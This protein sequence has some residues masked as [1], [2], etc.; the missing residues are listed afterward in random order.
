MLLP[1]LRGTHDAMANHTYV[2]WHP[3]TRVANGDRTGYT[4]IRCRRQSEGSKPT[5]LWAFFVELAGDHR[6][7]S[8]WYDVT[9]SL[10]HSRNDGPWALPYAPASSGARATFGTPCWRAC[11]RSYAAC[12]A[13][14]I[15]ARPPRS[16]PSHPSM[17]SAI[18]GEIPARPCSTRESVARVTRSCSTA[19]RPS[20]KGAS[21]ARPQ[22]VAQYAYNVVKP[23]QPQVR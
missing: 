23:R 8:E 9:R 18:S 3:D 5:F 10:P 7:L 1:H 21:T 4:A 6:S 13:I 12:L 2:A 22:G 11:Q 19:R 14:H 20:R 16:T 15:S 17:R